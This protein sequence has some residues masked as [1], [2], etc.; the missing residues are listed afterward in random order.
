MKS[1]IQF[2]WCS[3]VQVFDASQRGTALEALLQNGVDLDHS[4]GGMGSCGTCAVIVEN[5]TDFVLGP[6]EI[7]RELAKDRGFSPQERLA[8]QMEVV[9]G[10]RLKKR[11]TR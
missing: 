11:A 8:C 9:P 6:N 7:E 5:E 1:K 3:Q 2:F 4:C 10:L